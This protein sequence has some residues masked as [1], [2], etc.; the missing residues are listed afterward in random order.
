MNADAHQAAIPMETRLADLILG[1]GSADFWAPQCVT[2]EQTEATI[3]LATAVREYERVFGLM[4]TVQQL[5]LLTATANTIGRKNAAQRRMLEARAAINARAA[6]ARV[7]GDERRAE[8]IEAE[9]T[10]DYPEKAEDERELG[11]VG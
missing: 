11:Y 6:A 10:P 9:P 4:N 3:A 2:E 7:D 1:E 8:E 5:R